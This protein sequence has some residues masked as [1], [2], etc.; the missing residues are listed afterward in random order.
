[1]TTSADSLCYR[2]PIENARKSRMSIYEQA[3]P[4]LPP[5]KDTKL[6]NLVFNHPL[7]YVI[8]YPDDDAVEIHDRRSGRIGIV[9]GALAERFRHD[10][11]ILVSEQADDDRLGEFIDSFD[12]VINQSARLH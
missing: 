11:G 7:L 2:L 1:M 12:A 3:S 8:D 4:W 6:I 9:S 5:G 10:F